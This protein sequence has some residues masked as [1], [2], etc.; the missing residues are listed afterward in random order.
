MR[1]WGGYEPG[2]PLLG[3]GCWAGPG[4]AWPRSR[5]WIRNLPLPAPH[6]TQLALQVLQD[7]AQQELL[8]FSSLGDPECLSRIQL[9]SM[10]DPRSEIDPGS[11]IRNPSRIQIFSIPILTF[12]PSRIQ[13]Q[14]VKKAPDSGSAT[15]L[16]SSVGDQDLHVLGP[17]RSGFISQRYRSGSGLSTF[18]FLIK[19][20]SWLK[21]FLENKV[22]TQTFSKI[23]NF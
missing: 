9:F 16:L 7:P 15:L 19:V 6:L 21:K 8:L 18:P 4:R 23:L 1:G 3:P 5:F 17:P 14:G 13:D 20:L 10:P 11:R 2:V 22:L 12:Y